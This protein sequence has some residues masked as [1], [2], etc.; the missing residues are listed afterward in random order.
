MYKDGVKD[1]AAY[2]T[3]ILK[4]LLK[5]LSITNNVIKSLK[6]KRAKAAI[7]VNK[8]QNSPQSLTRAQKNKI[9]EEEL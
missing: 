9:V 1:L 5:E 6:E 3:I 4:K 8:V 7:K 2:K